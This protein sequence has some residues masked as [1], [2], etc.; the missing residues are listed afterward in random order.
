MEHP[1]EY[2]TRYGRTVKVTAKLLDYIQSQKDGAAAKARA[3][4][5]RTLNT[6]DQETSNPSSEQCYIEDLYKSATEDHAQLLD[7]EATEMN[8]LDEQDH[9]MYKNCF[10]DEATKI[11]QVSQKIEEFL[12][13]E[14]VKPTDSISRTSRGSK[15]SRRSQARDDELL[16]EM[17]KQVELEAKRA[18]L[19]KSA[20]LEEERKQ[21]E[22]RQ[23][24]LKRKE[25]LIALEAEIQ[26]SKAKVDIVET[27]S[28]ISAIRVSSRLS[29]QKK[30]QG[31]PFRF[32]PTQK[33]ASD[34]N[35]GYIPPRDNRVLGHPAGSRNDRE[36]PL[37]SEPAERPSV[38]EEEGYI[39]P[40]TQLSPS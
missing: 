2:K 26:A 17:K 37:R 12:A 19:L 1:Q 27:V 32:G 24:E 23:K 35:R 5:L 18:A 40:A 31:T 22:M 10:E 20:E 39:S 3:G 4:L 33:P 36:S 7:L 6:I 15:R 16:G 25:E 38:D 29:S 8:D 28:E 9:P 14:Q 13:Q 30:E 34:L 11:Q 21:L